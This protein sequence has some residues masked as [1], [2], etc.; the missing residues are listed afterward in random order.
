MFT[1][2]FTFTFVYFFVWPFLSECELKLPNLGCLYIL[3]WTHKP[4]RL[5]NRHSHLPHCLRPL[6]RCFEQQPQ[7][8]FQNRHW[9]SRLGLDPG[10]RQ[11]TWF[12]SWLLW[13]SDWFFAG[14][15]G[16]FAPTSVAIWARPLGR[17][18]PGPT[19]RTEIFRN[20]HP[21][22]LTWTPDNSGRYAPHFSYYFCNFSLFLLY[23]FLLPSNSHGHGFLLTFISFVSTLFQFFS[24]Q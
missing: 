20:S 11:W 6:P 4:H 8:C 13:P 9:H 12:R 2:T 1:F 17:S 21:D 10:C 3:F 19:S 18:S 5:H 23:V 16:L 7:F 14:D 22:D 24:K 15:G